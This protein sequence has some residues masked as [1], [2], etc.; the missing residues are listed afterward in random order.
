MKTN[1][2]WTSTPASQTPFPS[3][4]RFKT[5]RESDPL[6]E[7]PP[8][9]E[10][11]ERLYARLTPP[12]AEQLIGKAIEALDSGLPSLAE[13][14]AESLATL[15]D[16]NLD[17]LLGAFAER[18]HYCLPFAYRN[19]GP[20]IRDALIAALN[21]GLANPNIGLQA[22]AWI[23]D[24]VVRQRLQDWD[25]QTPPWPQQLFIQPSDYS[26][27]AA[28]EIT[29]QGRRDLFFKDCFA[30]ERLPAGTATDPSVT[31]GEQRSDLCPWCGKKLI[32]L[33]KLDLSDPQFSFIE[34]KAR[35]LPIVTCAICSAYAGAV[36][37]EVTADGEARW[38]DCN[39]HPGYLPGDGETWPA[40]PWQG[41]PIAL[42][43]RRAIEAV[44]WCGAPALTQIGGLPSWVQDDDFPDCPSCKRS[45]RFVAQID[46]GAFDRYEG[47]YYAFLCAPCRI[48]ATSYQ[49]S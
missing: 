9:P 2:S 44:D 13:I 33:L 31:I 28:W 29:P 21:K 18:S 11:V 3:S 47:I 37:G 23:G 39:K 4:S 30:V 41:V 45:M 35:A 19:S 24:D 20:E 10:P 46:Q 48:T 15:T 14:L 26:Y 5:P 12:E 7:Y 43:K 42:R 25:T 38:A 8:P 40:I 22:L 17:R 36:F 16:Y 1:D 34:L 6:I 49:Q 27:A 32:H